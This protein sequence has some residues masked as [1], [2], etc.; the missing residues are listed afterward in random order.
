MF[1]EKGVKHG[2]SDSTVHNCLID[3]HI[4][5]WTRFPVVS[6]VRRQTITSSSKR[7]PKMLVFV[8]DRNHQS[9][10]SY[11]SGMIEMFERTT[12]K[13]TGDEL[14]GIQ[15]SAITFDSITTE[16]AADQWRV[17]RFRAGE[18][19]VDCLCLIP[20]HIAITKENR[21][22]PLKDGVSSAELEKSLLGA[23]VGRIVDSL[24]FGWYE[25]LFRSYM[26]SK[27][28]SVGDF[29]ISQLTEHFQP[30]K[31][32]SS[33]GEQ[34]VGKSFALN[35]FVDTSFAGSAMRTT[36]GVWMSVTPTDAALIVALDFEGSVNS[37]S[38][39]IIAIF[40]IFQVCIA[41]N[42]RLRRTLFWC[43]STRQFRILYVICFVTSNYAQVVPKVLFR[44]NFAL[45]RDITGLFQSFQSSSTV[46]DPA[47]NPSLFQ[48]T[49]VII[50]KVRE[51]K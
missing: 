23:E 20:I 37:V 14:R 4:E 26:A 51:S 43:F 6:A 50:I 24:S 46:L 35:H 1:Q 3:C 44:N 28:F 39:T 19:L 40:I 8:T 49:L 10:A 15:V 45:N 5:V 9:F 34:S 30:V 18:W 16:L 25:S 42:A 27:V 47:A 31:V 41:L 48:S 11:F 7:H 21:F 38:L 22:I 29:M 17:S 33:M 36:E 12:Q 2:C 32:V 13:P